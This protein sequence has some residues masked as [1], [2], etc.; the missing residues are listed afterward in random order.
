M[1]FC[2]LTC[3]STLSPFIEDGLLISS[4][5]LICCH[6][7][8][9]R[10]CRRVAST[11]Q[12]HPQ[13]PSKS[14]AWDFSERSRKSAGGG[15]GRCLVVTEDARHRT[16]RTQL[17][18]SS[19]WGQLM[20]LKLLKPKQ[21]QMPGFWHVKQTN[22]EWISWISFA[23]LMAKNLL[24]TCCYRKGHFLSERVFQVGTTPFQAG[25]HHCLWTCSFYETWPEW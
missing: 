12:F 17:D 8:V 21:L 16:R 7:V 9:I 20:R 2:L 10:G 13:V 3:F 1:L 24:L 22:H 14:L 5:N 25:S 23:C 19:I 18:L 11:L 6:L 4:R 15:R